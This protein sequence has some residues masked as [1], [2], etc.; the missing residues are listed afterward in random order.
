MDAR[1]AGLFFKF[2]ESFIFL[3]VQSDR[4]DASDEE[5]PDV[6]ESAQGLFRRYV[7]FFIILILWCFFIFVLFVSRRPGEEC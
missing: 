3:C 4:Q 6:G 7:S 5:M 2:S 1:H